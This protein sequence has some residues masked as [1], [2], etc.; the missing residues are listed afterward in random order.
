LRRK[1]DKD[2]A[3]N[4]LSK[5]HLLIPTLSK[6]D[7]NEMEMEDQSEREKEQETRREALFRE[8][9]DEV[10]LG[11]DSDWLPPAKQQKEDK[12]KKKEAHNKR[13]DLVTDALI[14]LV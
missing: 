14:E 10:A 5:K 4:Q 3:K 12:K 1:K 7:V 11:D 6:R 13:M 2:K 8:I 9:E